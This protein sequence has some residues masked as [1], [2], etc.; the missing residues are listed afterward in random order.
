MSCDTCGLTPFILPTGPQGPQGPQGDQ[1]EQG[2]AGESIIGPQGPIG[3]AAPRSP[4]KYT[5]EFPGTAVNATFSISDFN[6]V[7]N[8]NGTALATLADY[9]VSIKR[10]VPVSNPFA[11]NSYWEEITKDCGLIVQSQGTAYVA[12]PNDDIS[13][14]LYRI[15]FIG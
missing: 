3:P 7:D 11:I 2:P 9:V 4:Q 12:F 13:P 10:Y 1:G 6:L 15:T 5:L 8:V 14:Q